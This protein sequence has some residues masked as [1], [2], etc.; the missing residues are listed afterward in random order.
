MSNARGRPRA[1]ENLGEALGRLP[2]IGRVT[3]ERLAYHL[4]QVDKREA[5]ALADAIVQAR[6]EIVPCRQCFNL[7]AQDPCWACADESRDRSL[8]LVVEG[9]RDVLAF[10]ASGYRGLYHVLQGR[11]APL[12]GIEGDDL[13]IR[14]LR[15]RVGALARKGLVEVCLATNPDLEGEATADAIQRGMN[16]LGVRVSR[17]AR[18]L[19]AGSS[20][21]QVQSSI[22]QD[23]LDGRRDYGER[24]P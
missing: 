3:S 16:E 14:A 20:I 13:T 4:L 7:D 11:I 21:V 10:E 9:P 1:L 2:G 18:G 22:L 19:P 5:L 15:K 6:A 12:E 24:K 17:I 23:A 8:I